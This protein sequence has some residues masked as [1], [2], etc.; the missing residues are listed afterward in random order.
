MY[1]LEA[2]FVKYFQLFLNGDLYFIN[3]LS[4]FAKQST[5]SVEFVV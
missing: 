2:I 4:T 1:H 3:S 5:K